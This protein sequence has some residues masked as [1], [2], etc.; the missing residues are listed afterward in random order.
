MSFSSDKGQTEPLAALI[1]VFALGVGLSLYV[2]VLDATLPSLTNDREIA[3]TAA[4]KFLAEAQSFGSVEPP[5]A[6]ATADASPNGYRLN[7][8]I[9]AAG[10]TWTEG[11]PRRERGSCVDRSISVRTAPGQIRPGRLEVCVWPE[12]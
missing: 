12:R 9:R 8:T 11:P 6:D 7:A 10:E 2:G 1:A 3:P 5:I 4:D